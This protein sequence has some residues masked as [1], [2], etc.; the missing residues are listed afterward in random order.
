MYSDY[1][2]IQVDK[3][4]TANRSKMYAVSI[5]NEIQTSLQNLWR[6][7]CHLQEL[8]KRAAHPC[9]FLALTPKDTQGSRVCFLRLKSWCLRQHYACTFHVQIV[10]F[11][12]FVSL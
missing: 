3:L 8:E 1:M 5:R 4:P 12:D 7:L 11:R 2:Y 6:K 10:T 9:F